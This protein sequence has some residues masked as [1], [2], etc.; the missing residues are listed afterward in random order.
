MQVIRGK[1]QEAKSNEKEQY[2]FFPDFLRNKKHDIIASDNLM[3]YESAAVAFF[4][5]G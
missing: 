2:L 4:I 1:R 5:K 3:K